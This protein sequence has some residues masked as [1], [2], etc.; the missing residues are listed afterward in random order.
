[1]NETFREFK[2]RLR[3]LD[4]VLQHRGLQSM[5]FA[6]AVSRVQRVVRK[7]DRSREPTAEL[8]T[9]LERAEILGK[10]LR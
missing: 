6:Q 5:E 10:A 7:S 9:L 4:E 3:K 2:G 1:M 8:Q